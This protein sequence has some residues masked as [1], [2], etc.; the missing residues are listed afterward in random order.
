MPVRGRAGSGTILCGGLAL[1]GGAVGFLA[2]F[3]YLAASF[4]Y[5]DVLDGRAEDVLPALL[6]TGDAGRAA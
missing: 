6:A 5:P 1:V 3:A 2:V 4:D